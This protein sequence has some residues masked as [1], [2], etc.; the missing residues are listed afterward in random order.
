M[1]MGLITRPEVVASLVVKAK[2]NDDKTIR[3]YDNRGDGSM[4]E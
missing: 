3:V 1:P 4:M 2:Y